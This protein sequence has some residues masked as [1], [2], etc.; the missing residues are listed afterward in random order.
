MKIKAIAL[1]SGGLD[2]I[3]A[4][5][6]I[7][8]QGIEVEGVTFETPF[9]GARKARKAAEKIGLSLVTINIT[10]EHLDMLKAPR[11][12]YGKN[13]NPCIDCHTLM[14]NIAGKRMEETGADFIF[15]GEVLG[16][17]PMS[18][19]RQSL[20]LVAKNS[21]YRDYILRPLSAKLLAETKPETEGKIDRQ[22]LLD[23]QGRSRKHQIE[24]AKNYGI[25]EYSTPAG[26]CLLTDPMFSKRL[27]DLFEH[28]GDFRISDIELLKFGRHFRS[29]KTTKIIVGRNSTDNKAI[30]RL[31][32]E[33]DIIVH[34]THFPGPTVLVPHGGD[35]KA[36][37][38][39]A[40]ICARYSDA[41]KDVET[42]VTC[43]TGG[44]I[45]LI[46]TKASLREDIE[47]WMI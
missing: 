23:I 24:M 25:T 27:Q 30:Q 6:L 42:N 14:L 35:N 39:A 19:T 5:R 18:Q 40:A 33:G 11:Y 10:E 38:H 21:G 7:L 17:R 20:V 3:L 9:F 47:Q 29:S 44:N 32:H 28:H 36:C 34:M 37:S 4:A 43:Q 16:Q 2:S 45:T 41:P 13:M 1:L 12:G 46:T 8:D 31:Y 22:K 26:G 15:T